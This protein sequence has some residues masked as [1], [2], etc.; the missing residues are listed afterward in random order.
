MSLSKNPGQYADVAAVLDAA[1]EAGGGRYELHSKSAAVRWRQRANHYRRLL[2]EIEKD[3]TSVFP[4][5]PASTPYDSL[6]LTLDE[7]VVVLAVGEP[8]GK[9]T[10]LK[11]KPL[12][13]KQPTA[14][15]DEELMR[16]AK[17]LAESLGGS[18]D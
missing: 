9:L 15:V 8:K 10:S 3:R 17:R 18:D 12:K 6:I 4:G 2:F 16:E 7:N 14:E 13:F 11:G 5:L 1:L